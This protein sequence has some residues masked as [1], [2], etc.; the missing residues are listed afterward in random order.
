MAPIRVTNA[1]GVV[2]YSVRKTHPERPG[3]RVNVGRFDTLAEALAAERRFERFDHI[4]DGIKVTFHNVRARGDG[5]WEMFFEGVWQG[6]F[7]TMQDA[8]HAIRRAKSNDTQRKRRAREKAM[9]AQRARLEEKAEEARA[10]A[11]DGTPFFWDEMI[12]YELMF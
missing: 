8:A 12:Q 2:K 10:R 4:P 6:R 5:T 11:L 7:G 9:A 1:R 3:V